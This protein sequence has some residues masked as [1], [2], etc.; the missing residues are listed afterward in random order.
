[1]IAVLEL[2]PMNFHVEDWKWACIAAAILTGLAMLVV[3][4]FHP[5]GFE[6]QGAWLLALLPATLATYPLSDYVDKAAPHAEPVVSWT[7]VAR[8]NF[9]WYW[10]VSYVV[11]KIRRAFS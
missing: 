6:T 5:G 9:L 7:S 11:L 3:F 8:F 2:A 4:A 1:M 10:L